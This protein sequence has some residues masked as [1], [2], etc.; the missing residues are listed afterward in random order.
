MKKLLSPL[1]IVVTLCAVLSAAYLIRVGQSEEDREDLAVEMLKGENLSKTET[2]VFSMQFIEPNP[3]IDYK[4][5]E[6]APKT[7]ATAEL[8]FR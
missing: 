6:V 1:V 8:P 2:S 5:I 7:S 3:G 4:I